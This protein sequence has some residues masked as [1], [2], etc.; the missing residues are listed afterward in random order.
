MGNRIRMGV[1]HGSSHANFV[2]KITKFGIIIGGAVATTSKTTARNRIVFGT[3]S[4]NQPR[5]PK[6]TLHCQAAEV[7]RQA[8]KRTCFRLF[9][10]KLLDGTGSPILARRAQ[11]GAVAGTGFNKTCS[12]PMPILREPQTSLEV[13]HPT[14][15]PVQPERGLKR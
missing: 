6:P 9:C 4:G 7:R 11:F 10:G 14:P 13:L 5:S 12:K 1:W 15:H 3:L 2:K 8:Q